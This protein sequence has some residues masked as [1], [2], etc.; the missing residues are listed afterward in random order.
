MT[1]KRRGDPEGFLNLRCPK[2][3]VADSL[4][5]RSRDDRPG[6]R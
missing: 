6:V 2:C 5:V 3:G 4:L 1:A